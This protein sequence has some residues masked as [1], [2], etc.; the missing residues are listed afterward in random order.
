MAPED[1][2]AVLILAVAQHLV[3][4]HCESVEVAN[5]QRAEVAVEGIVDERLVD[6]EV[7][8]GLGPGA[9]R[10]RPGVRLGGALTGGLLLLALVG[11]RRVCIRSNRI[12]G[13]I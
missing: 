3:K 11:E 9:G 6:R 8:W 1:N 12:G 13:Q 4:L 5:V 7:D 10:P 2:R